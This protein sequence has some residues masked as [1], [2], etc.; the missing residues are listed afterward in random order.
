ML[1]EPVLGCPDGGKSC[2]FPRQHHPKTSL[3]F[4]FTPIPVLAFIPAGL[5]LGWGCCGRAV[6]R[7][8]REGAGFLNATS[9]VGLSEPPA[10]CGLLVRLSSLFGARL[11]PIPIILHG[12]TWCLSHP[13]DAAPEALLPCADGVR[14]CWG[15][16][17]W[18]CRWKQLLHPGANESHR[19]QQPRAAAA[20]F[21]SQI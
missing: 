3:C 11:P 8:C 17:G 19:E 10:P 4:P 7:L 21:G 5:N 16:A 20:A 14:V 6:W 15:C 18:G 12:G 2:S 1:L 9:S 13:P